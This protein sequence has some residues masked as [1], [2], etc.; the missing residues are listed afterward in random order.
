MQ[1]PVLF[2]L[3]GMKV[4]FLLT[5]TVKNVEKGDNTS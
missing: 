4:A 2:V 1:E 3:A 5:L